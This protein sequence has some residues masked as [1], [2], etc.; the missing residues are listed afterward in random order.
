MKKT[1]DVIIIGGGVIG[2]A[3]AYFLRQKQV[4]VVL[5]E[6]GALGGQASGAAAGLLAPL[7]PLSG[8]G[9]FADLVLAGFSLLR[10]LLPALEEESGIHVGYEQAGALRTIRNPKRVAHLQKRLAQW[11]PL[12]LELYWLDGEEA[13]RHEPLL[14]SDICGAVYAPEESLLH[15]PSVVQAFAQGAQRSGAYLYPYQEST[16]LLTQGTRVTGIVTA[17]EEHVSCQHL[18]IASGAW[19]AYS[20]AQL[21][22]TLPISPLQGQILSYSKQSLPLRHIVFGEAVYVVPHANAVL[23]GATKDEFGFDIAVTRDGVTWL[24]STAA[25]LLPALAEHQLQA[26]WAGLRPR[27]PDSRPILDRLVPWENVFVATGHNSVGIILSAI[28]GQSMADMITTGQVPPLVQP[29][30]MQRF[31]QSEQE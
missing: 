22:V 25:R 17:R 20:A 3:I 14:A 23:V 4:D 16:R 6:R 24:Q 26:A 28:T 5:V 13:R 1:A 21:Q 27:T 18:I 12:G 11:Q 19:A 8:P 9:P 31:A 10:A 30:S 2:C 7:G 15:A 29:F